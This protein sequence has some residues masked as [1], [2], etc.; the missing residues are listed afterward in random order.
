M[1]NLANH[2]LRDSFGISDDK[3][4]EAPSENPV[5]TMRGV[6]IKIITEI[7][8]QRGISEQEIEDLLK[9]GNIGKELQKHHTAMERANQ[10]EGGASEAMIL[11]FT[12]K[13]IEGLL[14]NYQL[15][16]ARK[17]IHAKANHGNYYFN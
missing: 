9:Q 1:K 12:R 16:Q 6:D 2:S 13:V 7:A 14:E 10:N 15:I 5:P 17:K 3:K 4:G 8:R 11:M